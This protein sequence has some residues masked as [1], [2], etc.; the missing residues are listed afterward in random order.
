MI[1]PSPNAT[2]SMQEPSHAASD[3]RSAD[4][5][6]FAELR[7][8]LAAADFT[9]DRIESTFGTHTLSARPAE[10]VVRGRRLSDDTFSKVAKLFVLGLPVEVGAAPAT[11]APVDVERLV[12]LGLARL[13]GGTVVPTV[14]VVPHGDYY[15]ASDRQ[16]DTAAK[17]RDFVPGI[18][19]PSVMLAKLA[20][21]RRVRAALDLGTGCGI[22]ALL[23]AKHCERVLATDVNE[24]ALEFAEFNARLNGLSGIE[25]RQGD[26]FDPVSDERFDLIVSNPPYVVSPDLEFLYRDNPLA[27]DELCRRLVE[28]TP[29]FL[30]EGGFAHLLV[31]WVGATDDWI[32]RDLPDDEAL[33]DARLA[34]VERHRLEQAL[35]C[36]EGGFRVESQTLALEEGS[37]FAP[38]S[39]ATR[40]RSCHTCTNEIRSAT[41]SRAWRRE[42]RLAANDRERFVPAALPIVRRLLALGFLEPVA[43]PDA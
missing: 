18:Q 5:K 27:G 33:L 38:R 8:S 22:Q 42:W 41:H 30:N 40:R 11:L 6:V 31:S 29:A 9:A 14:R 1:F 23:A 39:T 16:T 19:A 13:D 24:R 37:P 7:A 12:A 32:L 21:R 43:R 36:E 25:F 28:E 34:L 35:R 26:G 3:L 17:P 4:E 10:T 2:R 20:V 15:V